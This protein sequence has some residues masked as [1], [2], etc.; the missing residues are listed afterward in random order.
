MIL[1]KSN[2]SEYKGNV[3]KIIKVIYGKPT[4]N[5]ILKYKK[6]KDFSLRSGARQGC[7]FLLP[8]FNIVLAP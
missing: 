8:L 5:I 7:P 4:A 3:P 2:Q 6:L 1:K